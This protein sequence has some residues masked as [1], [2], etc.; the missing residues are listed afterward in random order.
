MNDRNGIKWT[1]EET[2]LALDLYLKIPYKKITKTNL[3]VIKL[4]DLLGRTPDSVYMKVCNIAS[5]DTLIKAK[6]QS[7]LLNGSKLDKEI[8]NEFSC[9]LEDLALNVAYILKNNYANDHYLPNVLGE[10][11]DGLYKDNIVKQ[12]I[13]QVYFRNAVL[14]IY[15]NKCCVTGID[16]TELLIASHIKPWK[17]SDE[18]TERTNPCNGLCLNAFHDKAFDKG[19]ITFDSNFKMLISSKLENCCMDDDTKRWLKSYKGV[20]LHFPESFAPAREFMQYH[21][22]KIFLG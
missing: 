4:A 21:N 13:G 3:D 11:P 8:F 14:K 2:I 18:H 5:N 20:A 12:R 7:A 6:N 15:G 1:R 19:L 22:D 9:N 16:A 10:M 17:D